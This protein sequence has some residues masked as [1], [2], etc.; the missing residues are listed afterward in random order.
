MSVHIIPSSVSLVSWSVA[1]KLEMPECSAGWN[2][3]GA[4]YGRVSRTG[5][6]AEDQ[7]VN[8]ET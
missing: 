4:V 5:M 7:V 1:A 8:D 3:D 2:C 6:I